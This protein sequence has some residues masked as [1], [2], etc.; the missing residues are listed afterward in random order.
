MCDTMVD[1]V[2]VCEDCLRSDP[3]RILIE[4]LESAANFLRGMQLDPWI[5]SHARDAMRQRV[6]AIDEL[7]QQATDGGRSNSAHPN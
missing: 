6:E 3:I 1:G 4:A 5:P 2:Y 7:T